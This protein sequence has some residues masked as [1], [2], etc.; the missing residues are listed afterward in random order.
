MMEVL[1]IVILL[2]LIPAAIAQRKGESFVVWWIYGA[3]LFIVA[4]PHALLKKPNVPTLEANAAK[5]G[6]KKCLYCA[7]M[8]KS[9]ARV[10]RY[11]SRELQTTSGARPRP[12]ESAAPP[13]APRKEPPREWDISSG[14]P[15]DR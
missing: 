3:L 12:P 14:N 10:C 5:S 4:L 15:L 6:M 1:I 9:E 11:C 2:G 7:E 13:T 8:I